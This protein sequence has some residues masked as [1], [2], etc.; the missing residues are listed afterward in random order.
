M[1]TQRMIP[2]LGGMPSK[3]YG[4]VAQLTE[5]QLAWRPAENEWSIKEVLCHLRD[6]AEV[7]GLRLRRIAMEE[8]PFLPAFDQDAYARDRDY[9]AEIA[10][11]ALMTY[12]QHRQA[13]CDLLRALPQ[14]GWSRAG[15]HEEAGQMTLREMAERVVNHELEHLEQLR[16]LRAKATAA[17][18]ER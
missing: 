16:R 6:A 13:T 9:Q 15:V 12:A 4:L 8:N 3:V 7:Y 17:V 18:G 2:I 1:D 10:P 5:A 14:E 11:A